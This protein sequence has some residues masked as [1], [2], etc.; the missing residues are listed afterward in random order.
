MKKGF[1]FLTLVLAMN[2]Q[3][4]AATIFVKAG[5][6]GN[7]TSWATAT[8]NLQ[9]ALQKATVGDEIWVSKGVYLPT[10]DNNRT[11]SFHIKNSVAL[12]GGFAGSETSIGERIIKANQTVLSGEIGT[13]QKTDNTFNVLYTASATK[14]TI[15][16]GFI[17]TGGYAGGNETLASRFTSGG[18]MYNE[19]G[20]KGNQSNPTI[21]NCRF[22]ENTARD[23]G[24]LYN[25]AGNGGT[26]KPTLVN[27]TF[28]DNKAFLGGGAIFNNGAEKGNCLP[29]IIENN[30]NKNL[31]G[32]GGAIFN[33]GKN[34]ACTSHINDSKFTNNKAMIQGGGIFNLGT[35]GVSQS[36]LI[37]C[38]FNKNTA[39]KGSTVANSQAKPSISNEVRI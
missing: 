39:P 30:F 20:K 11:I 26:C 9:A 38:E 22:I 29:T 8:G 2:W 28:Q 3:A 27:C 35:N 18:G 21:R 13:S 25:N 4:N 19:G 1:L 23:G 37:N 15:I 34:G 32:F 6:T 31:A 5:A 10:T 12:Y 36:K 14:A 16:D 33:Y 7:G 24:A 17:I